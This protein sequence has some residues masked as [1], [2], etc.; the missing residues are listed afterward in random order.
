[1]RKKLV[2]TSCIICRCLYLVEIMALLVGGCLKAVSISHGPSALIPSHNSARTAGG[3]ELRV[4][5]PASSLR[6][7]LAAKLSDHQSRNARHGLPSVGSSGYDNGKRIMIAADS[8]PSASTPVLAS[9]ASGTEESESPASPSPGLKLILDNQREWIWRGIRINYSKVE[10]QGQGDA[11]VAKPAVVLVH[12]FGASIG[13]WRRY[14]GAG[15]ESPE[16]RT[17]LMCSSA[18]CVTKPRAIQRG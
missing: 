1:M 14:A 7:S 15:I 9:D 16:K 17:V 12:G 6:R 5:T 3:S 8:S 13:H 4:G 18:Q 11:D 10:P 2:G